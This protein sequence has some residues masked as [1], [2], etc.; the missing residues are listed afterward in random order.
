[1]ARFE[2]DILDYHPK[3][4]DG[5]ILQ[6][7][8]GIHEE[9]ALN[10]AERMITSYKLAKLYLDPMKQTFDVDHYLA[11]HRFLF[12][13]IYPFAGEIREESISKRIPFCL[14]Q[15]IYF[16]L[17][18]TLKNA[19]SQI[20]Q[21]TSR[22]ELLKFITV[23]Y[24]DLDIIH[25]FREGNGRTEREFIRQLIDHICQKNHL[26]PYYLDYGLIEDRE[27]YIDAV[28]KADALLDYGDLFLL[29]DSILVVR[30]DVLTDEKAATNRKK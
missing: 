8:L 19:M 24:S 13:D 3:H 23:L 26:E 28:V 5:D 1:M 7:K 12:E 21:I 25:P 30:Q 16:E 10:Q 15:F 14:P 18:R 6:N 11:I 20:S 2:D 4:M 22:E 17:K 29:F 27:G 9:D